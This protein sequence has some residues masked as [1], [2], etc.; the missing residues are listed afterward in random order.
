MLLTMVGRQLPTPAYV[1]NTRIAQCKYRGP[2]GGSEFGSERKITGKL[3]DP[4]V[5]LQMK[6]FRALF[7]GRE[8]REI[9][10]KSWV[11]GFRS[12]KRQRPLNRR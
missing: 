5:E 6:R 10:Q 2:L 4:L 9:P 12:P 1:N 7:S 3:G 8:L 11:P